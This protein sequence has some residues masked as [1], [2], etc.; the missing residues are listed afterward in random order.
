[1]KKFCLNWHKFTLGQTVGTYSY[2]CTLFSTVYQYSAYWD[3]P[4]KQGEFT[5]VTEGF[6]SQW[7]MRC[8]LNSVTRHNLSMKNSRSWSVLLWNID[9]CIFL[10]NYLGEKV[11]HR[12]ILGGC[13]NVESTNPHLNYSGTTQKDMITYH[14]FLS[15]FDTFNE[16]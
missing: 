4:K 6:M 15:L 16:Y 14:L 1:M 8:G 7:F 13:Y 12:I 9:G 2:F 10:K 11:T 5:M 3:Q